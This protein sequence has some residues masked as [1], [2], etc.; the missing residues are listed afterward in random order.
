MRNERRILINTGVLSA[1]EGIGLLANLALVTSF[2]R[3]FGATALGHYATAT[4]VGALAAIGV[5]FGTQALLIREISRSPGCA[6][7]W[8]G[9]L[10]PVQLILA[11]L[12]WLVACA[13]SELLIGDGTAARLV[14]AV[15]GYQI[16]IRIASVLLTPL[17][18]RELMLVSAGGDLAHRL[19]ALALMLIAIRLGAAPAA[20]ALAPIAGALLLIAYAWIQGARRGGRPALRLAPTEAL[21]LFRRAGPFLGIV[22]LTVLYVR[23]ATLMLS[24]LASAAAVGLYAVANRFMEAAAV[25]PT[26]FNAAVYPALARVAAASHADARTLSAR[27][28]RLLLIGSIPLAALITVFA[29]DI[30]RVCFGAPYRDAVHVLQVLAWTLPLRGVQAVLSS[31]LAVMDQQ[32]ALARARMIALASFVLASPPLI[33]GFGLLGAA[34]AVLLCDAVQLAMYWRLLR[35]ARAAPG[36]GT[37]VLAP[38]SAAVAATVASALATHSALAWRITI[39]IAVMIAGLWVFRAIRPVDLR[40]LRAIVLRTE[41]QPIKSRPNSR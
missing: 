7:E 40:F 19:L 6:R 28:V 20:A 13:V 14:M 15:C 37:A 4:A 31:Q 30:V 33:V 29:P 24:G 39:V 3:S 35:R 8:L 41:E 32:V 18:A 12:V 10:L 26:M 38:A 1:T 9:V 2:A 21:Q 25:A 36:V 22:V 17:Q 16:L 5:T 23:G 34:A 27:S 11:P